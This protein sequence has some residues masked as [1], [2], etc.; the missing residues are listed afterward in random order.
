MF[1]SCIQL[2]YPRFRSIAQNFR[3]KGLGHHP[4]SHRW[5]MNLQLNFCISTFHI[6]P[7][8][9]CFYHDTI[10][11]RVALPSSDRRIDPHRRIVILR[12]IPN[13]V[14]VFSMRYKDISLLR[15]LFLNE[16]LYIGMFAHDILT[17]LWYI[18]RYITWIYNNNTHKDESPFSKCELRYC[19]IRPLDIL[20][21]SYCTRPRFYFSC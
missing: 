7:P 8:A 16:L 9:C 19:K 4:T 21:I 5:L 18:Y 6:Y 14:F 13:L 1:C 10:T 17:Y 2:N 11:R 20:S 12:K 3:S 15:H